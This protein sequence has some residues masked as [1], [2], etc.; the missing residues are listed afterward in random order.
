MVVCCRAVG[1]DRETLRKIVNFNSSERESG[2]EGGN[3]N[4]DQ[5]EVTE[6]NSFS[7]S[8]AREVMEANRAAF[9]LRND[10]VISRVYPKV[11]Q[12]DNS[13]A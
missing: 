6:M 12:R 13:H 9:Q 7:E 4:D 8:K 2:E 11:R 3:D 5:D 1:M 10:K